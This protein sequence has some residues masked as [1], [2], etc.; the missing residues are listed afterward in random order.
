[1]YMDRKY[2]YMLVY[3]YIM[4]RY[5]YLGYLIMWQYITYVKYAGAQALGTSSAFL[6]VIAE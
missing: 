5:I 2:N 6:G 3:N 4:L 1:M